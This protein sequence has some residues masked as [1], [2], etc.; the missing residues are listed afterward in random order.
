MIFV[1]VDAELHITAI[2]ICEREKDTPVLKKSAWECYNPFPASSSSST[3]RHLN[4]ETKL[5]TFAFCQ[6]KESAT[7]VIR[8]GKKEK[9][10]E[11]KK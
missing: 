1:E 10:I 2:S 4:R 5:G 9:K 7:N 3:T 6:L 8:K 11:I